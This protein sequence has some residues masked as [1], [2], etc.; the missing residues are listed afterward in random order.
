MPAMRCIRRARHALPQITKAINQ[1]V[2]IGARRRYVTSKLSS[3]SHASRLTQKA[4]EKAG[5]LSE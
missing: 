5:Y 2:N 1:G 4:S 3:G